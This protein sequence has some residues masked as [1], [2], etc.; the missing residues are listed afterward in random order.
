M[1]QKKILPQPY[2]VGEPELLLQVRPPLVCMH[3]RGL[4]SAL[5]RGKTPGTQKALKITRDS[6]PEL[7][8]VT[9]RKK[10]V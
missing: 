3:V 9:M 5:R 10:S 2:F 4:V 7:E 1:C 8:A 6:F